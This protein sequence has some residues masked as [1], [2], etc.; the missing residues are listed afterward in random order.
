MKLFNI[1]LCLTI[2]VFLGA[3]ELNAQFSPTRGCVVDASG[4]CVGNGILTALPFLR[5]APDAR[6]GAMG[7]MGV[8]TDPNSNSLHYNASSLVFSEELS[9]L[10]F[11]YT[12][13]LTNLNIDDIFLLYLSGYYKLDKNQMIGGGVRY[14]SLGEIQFTDNTG[15][16]IGMGKPIEGEVM[17][18]YGRK[19]G[20]KLSASL[21]GKYLFSN[22]A[23]GFFLNGQEIITGQS[24]AADIGLNYRTKKK[25]G[26]YNS[27]VSYGLA[28]TNFGSKI[29]YT[30]DNSIR[31]FIPTN[32][33]LGT[34]IK[35]ELDKYNSLSFGLDINKL[36]IPTPVS[37]LI[38]NSDG[39]RVT[40]PEYDCCPANGVADYRERPLF[41][42]VVESFYDAPGGFK[43]EIRE[44]SFSVGFEYWY[45]QQFAFR[46][47]YYYE[48][49]LKG[50]RRFF[51]I[52]AGVKYNIFGLD[53]SYLIPSSNVPNPLDNTLRF[54]FLFDLRVFES[55][56][57]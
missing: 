51:T 5:I 3:K 13:W 42:G 23:S 40:N 36:L 54:S 27:E 35:M 39:S 12:P 53:F 52:G 41:R 1:S 56:R 31:D 18:S 14:F 17:L 30:R 20:D 57:N 11:T 43:E 48:D 55:D 8:A 19:L 4:N 7:D 34:N 38:L 45:A 33:G 44:L 9:G 25:I 22:L 29:S 16:N 50:N 46:G 26:G 15:N 49:A 47:G 2:I 21:S 6:S 32:L 37:P 28:I 10:S 24:F